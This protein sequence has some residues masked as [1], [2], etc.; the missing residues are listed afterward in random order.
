[1][2]FRPESRLMELRH[3]LESEQ[4]SSYRATTRHA[5]LL[6]PW[7]RTVVLDGSAVPNDKKE[8][9]VQRTLVLHQRSASPCVASHIQTTKVSLSSATLVQFVQTLYMLTALD[10]RESLDHKSCI[11]SFLLA[12]PH[13]QLRRLYLPHGSAISQ[14]TLNCFTQL[15][16]LD[17]TAC[18]TFT[19]VDFCA[20]TLEVLYASYCYDLTDEGLRKAT[21]LRVLHVSGC[22]WVTSVAPFARC[23]VELSASISCGIRVEALSACYALQVLIAHESMDTLQPFAASLRELHATGRGSQ[24]GDAALTLATNLVP[25]NDSAPIL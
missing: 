10:L 5:T 15:E 8:V 20:A 3:L 6:L 12:V 9:Y 21:M 22:Q 25:C 7:L 23:L 19:N 18:K 1:M 17:V 14:A 24:L 13:S 16:E 4:V 11:D 2:L